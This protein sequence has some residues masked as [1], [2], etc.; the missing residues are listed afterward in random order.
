VAAICWIVGRS[1]PALTSS[2]IAVW[3]TTW[4]D[5]AW[6]EAGRDHR[7]AQRLAHSMAITS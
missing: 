3:R 5:P 4:G 6:I 1:T 2:V 7:L